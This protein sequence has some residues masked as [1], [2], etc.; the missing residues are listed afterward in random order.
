MS[1]ERVQ[2]PVFARFY[3]RLSAG[4]DRAGVGEH[5]SRVLRGLTGPVIE[6]G[7]GNGLNFRH[8]PATVTSVVAVEPE[9]HLRA[10]AERNAALSA[11]PVSVVDGVAERLPAGDGTF[12]AVVATL[13]LCSV[14]DQ[15]AVLRELYRVVR[16]GGQFR[17][18]EHVS[19]RS[20]A[21]RRLQR[22]ADA[23]VWPA[24][25]GGCHAGRDTVAAIE[26]AGFSI[27]ELT[28]YR[29]PDGWLPWPTAPHARGVA[30]RPA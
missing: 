22:L 5:R 16:P 28:R 2:H 29:L 6:V 4:A 18:M 8:Y 23:T 7:A 19:A 17:F 26:A 11:V 20:A 30:V 21:G 27:T 10:I 3:A 12:D 15:A 1:S 25:F 9:P 13:M 24:C 14:R